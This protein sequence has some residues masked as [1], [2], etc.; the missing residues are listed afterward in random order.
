MRISPVT[1]DIAVP[2]ATVRLERIKPDSGC[3]D[4]LD[5]VMFIPIV[6]CSVDRSDT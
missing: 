5:S 1:R 6:R 4:E 3:S 2:V